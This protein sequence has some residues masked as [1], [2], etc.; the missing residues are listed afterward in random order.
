MK[1]MEAPRCRLCE[2]NHWAREGCFGM[3]TN[4]T[5]TPTEAKGREAGRASHLPAS[6]ASGGAFTPTTNTTRE[7]R[8]VLKGSTVSTPTA[9]PTRTAATAKANPPKAKKAKE[10]APRSPEPANREPSATA[11]PAKKK[12]KKKGAKK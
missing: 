7:G 8:R 11:G 5:P 4:R 1:Q 2:K 6:G 12:A 3:L 9:K 10:G